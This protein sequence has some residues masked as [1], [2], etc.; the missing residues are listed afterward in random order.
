M[1][2]L[3]VLLRLCLLITALAMVG[4]A[5]PADDPAAG[6]QEEEASEESLESFT[7]TEKLPADS[8]ISFPVDI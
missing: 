2:K 5:A 3:F 7:P 4:P 1:K 6:D 8:A